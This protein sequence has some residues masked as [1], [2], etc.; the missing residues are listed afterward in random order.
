MPRKAKPVASLSQAAASLVVEVGA[1]SQA[2]QSFAVRGGSMNFFAPR[3]GKTKYG[4]RS[5]GK[6]WDAQIAMTE[7]FKD[8]LPRDVSNW[9]EL[10]RRVNE[11]R[12]RNPIYE[13]LDSMTVRRAFKE[14]HRKS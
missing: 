3:A 5:G 4:P 14:L 12:K 10:T 8:G 13:E 6:R 9:E 2:D 7:I 11:I 1:S